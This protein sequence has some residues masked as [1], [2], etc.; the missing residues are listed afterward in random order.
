MLIKCADVSN[1][2]RPLKLCIEWATRIASEYCQQVSAL[3]YL[4]LIIVES[5][6]AASFWNVLCK[7]D[8]NMQRRQSD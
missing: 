2:A 6:V 5:A 7:V 4:L 3:I 1:P 8:Y